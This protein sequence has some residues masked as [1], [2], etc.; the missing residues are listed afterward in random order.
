M[1]MGDREPTD[2]SAEAAVD[3]TKRDAASARRSGAGA[4][5]DRERREVSSVG[6]GGDREG[7][8]VS[9]VRRS[10]AGAL[11]EREGRGVR[12]VRRAGGGGSVRGGV[13]LVRRGGVVVA[14]A[15]VVVGAAA[16]PAA[17]HTTLQSATPGIG[18]TVAAPSQVV[19]TFADPVRFPE[20][21]VTDAGGKRHQ[22]GKPQAVDNTVTEKISGTLAGGVYVVGWRV[23]APDGHPVSGEYRFIVAG[24]SG[25]TAVAPATKSSGFA[26][27]W[28]GLGAL[29]LAG[30]GAGVVLLRRTV[31]EEE[32]VP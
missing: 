6:P 17:A 26:W 14:S 23:V 24:G 13:G 29:L 2:Q 27:W 30:A 1:S 9:A 28:V 31:R 15:A 12:P 4:L 22:D 5:G 25:S 10:G 21:V 18:A 20:V 3:R 11:G 8:E 19:L 16:W 32:T 7:C